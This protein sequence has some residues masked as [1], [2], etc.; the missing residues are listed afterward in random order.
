MNKS[1]YPRLLSK[2][3]RVF[4]SFSRS[5]V[6]TLGAAYLVLS[7]LKVSILAMSFI[8][9]ALYAFRKII[10][11]KLEPSFVK[12]L[13]FPKELRYKGELRRLYVKK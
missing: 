2:K 8:L 7:S 10:L 11:S 1:V 9:L 6:I 5:D 4:A 13:M 3:A 12:N